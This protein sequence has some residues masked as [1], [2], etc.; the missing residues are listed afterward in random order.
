MVSPDSTS[1]APM[2]LSAIRT[3]SVKDGVVGAYGVH[4]GLAGQQLPHG[5]RH[6]PIL[7]S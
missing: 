2:F 1:T 3:E 4:A 5:G 6:G 7:R